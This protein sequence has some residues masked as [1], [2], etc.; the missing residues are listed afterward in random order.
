[1][2]VVYRDMLVN[3]ADKIITLKTDDI[4]NNIHLVEDAARDVR[5]GVS[6]A[7]AIKNLLIKIGGVR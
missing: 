1:M 7:T 3:G 2:E 5:I 6:P 4:V